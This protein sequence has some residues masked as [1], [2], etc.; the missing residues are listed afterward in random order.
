MHHTRFIAALAFAGVWIYPAIAQTGGQ[1]S[2]QSKT[3]TPADPLQRTIRE[4]R[5]TT[6][7]EG[8]AKTQDHQ[9]NAAS[10]QAIDSMLSSTENLNYI[11]DGYLR[12]LSGDG[13]RPD[14]AARVAELRALLGEKKAGAQEAGGRF[15]PTEKSAADLE[16]SMLA[17]AVDWY[18]RPPAESSSI[19]NPAN[20]EAERARLLEAALSLRESQSTAAPASADSAALKAELDRL[21]VSCHSPQR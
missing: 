6:S 10:G 14:V 13:C 18:K 5:V 8:D 4:N 11:R 9:P 17:L 1:Q 12:V 20:R 21:L 7:R 15:A 19:S 16:S 3:A 2:D